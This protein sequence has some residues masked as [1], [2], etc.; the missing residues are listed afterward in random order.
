MYLN[1]RVDIQG[2]GHANKAFAVVCIVKQI[3]L[4]NSTTL[5]ETFAAVS[6]YIHKTLIYDCYD[7]LLRHY[8]QSVFRLDDISITHMS[9]KIIHDLT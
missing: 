2:R 4:K 8:T 6:T 5:W 7:D 3:F 9:T 1:G